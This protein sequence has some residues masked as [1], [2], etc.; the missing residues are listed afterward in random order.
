MDI[1]QID[2]IMPPYKTEV[3]VGYKITIAERWKYFRKIEPK[4]LTDDDKLMERC[5]YSFFNGRAQ[6]QVAVAEKINNYLN[7][8]RINV[9]N[10]KA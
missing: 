4:A 7:E 3:E 10:I 2:E 8:K 5:V 6:D 1:T 9:I